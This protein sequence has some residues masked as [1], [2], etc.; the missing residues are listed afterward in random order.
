MSWGFRDGGDGTTLF[1]DVG[2][3]GRVPQANLGPDEDRHP[4]TGAAAWS[5]DC[6]RPGRV[7]SVPPRPAGGT[8]DVAR[9]DPSLLRKQSVRRGRHQPSLE[10]SPAC[11]VGRFHLELKLLVLYPP[12]IASPEVVK[13]RG[14]D[15]AEAISV[16]GR[17]VDAVLPRGVDEGQLG[18]QL[19]TSVGRARMAG[20]PDAA[21]EQRREEEDTDTSR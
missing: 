12:P 10:G 17:I 3:V 20:L 8:S 14:R 5:Q 13:P 7:P 2:A 4:S 11:C 9:Q 15:V 1:Q 19:R 18:R 6:G 16:R 21:S